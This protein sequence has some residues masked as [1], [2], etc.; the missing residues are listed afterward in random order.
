[1]QVY[2][3]HAHGVRLSDN[4]LLF[5]YGSESALP[6]RVSSDL[7]LWAMIIRVDCQSQ[8][9]CVASLRMIFVGLTVLT[10]ILK[11]NGEKLLKIQDD[12]QFIQ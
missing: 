12:G 2:Q 10:A 9:R 7:H 5:L 1:M 11:I 6:S 8:T 3:Q 4:R